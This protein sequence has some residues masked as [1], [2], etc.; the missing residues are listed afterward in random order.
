MSLLSPITSVLATGKNAVLERFL[1]HALGEAGTV[2]RLAL[3]ANAKTLLFDLAL[4]GEAQFLPI[5]VAYSLRRDAHGT[6][7]TVRE[8][9]TSKPWADSWQ[10]V[11]CRSDESARRPSAGSLIT[12]E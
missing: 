10:S 5:A 12:V 9:T 11:S 6:W 3:D 8:V 4:K 1:Q 7:L 2:S